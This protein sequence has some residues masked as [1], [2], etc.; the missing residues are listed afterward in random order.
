[1]PSRS[2]GAVESSWNISEITGLRAMMGSGE[3]R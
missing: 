3:N 1:V 2:F